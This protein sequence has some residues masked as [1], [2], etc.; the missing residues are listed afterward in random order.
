MNLLAVFNNHVLWTGLVAWALAQSFKIPIEY[1]RT[2]RWNWA[3]F[4]SAGGMPS[5]HAALVTCAAHSIGLH[6][7]FDTPL[8]GWAVL[9]AM[10]VVYDATGVRRQAGIQAQRINL[11]VNE[12]LK[13]HPVS[14]KQLREVLGHTPLQALAGVL[15]GLLVAQVLWFILH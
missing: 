10:I 8:Y 9:V 2:G 15:L 5:S 7:G 14:N 12:L 6:H 11:I 3:L 13:R 1:I 4:F